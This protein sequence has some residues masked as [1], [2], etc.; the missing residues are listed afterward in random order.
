MIEARQNL[1]LGA[2]AHAEI[3]SSGAVDDFDG[4]LSGELVVGPLARNTV[5]APPRPSTDTS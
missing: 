4:R 3:E 5:P 2:E 1:A